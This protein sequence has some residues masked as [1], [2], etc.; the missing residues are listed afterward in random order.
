ML[1]F[2]FW[3]IIILLIISLL[4]LIFRLI[5]WIGI[6]SFSIGGLVFFGTFM[7][8][9]IQDGGIG[10]IAR[11]IIVLVIIYCIYKGIKGIIKVIVWIKGDDVIGTDAINV[12]GK[13]IVELKKRKKRIITY[14]IFYVIERC[15]IIS[16]FLTVLGFVFA[17]WYG[18]IS[19]KEMFG[20]LSLILLI[21]N[22]FPIFCML[23]FYL[24]SLNTCSEC[25]LELIEDNNISF[26]FGIVH[27]GLLASFIT[28][29]II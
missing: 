5:M 21:Y 16:I 3:T 11:L 12:G 20:T 15:C 28:Y 10:G 24:L 26:N 2:L 8:K 4:P 23:L 7:F 25:L 1:H 22:I 18:Y 17:T 29:L 19:A 27:I 13:N 6:I 14:R 9:F